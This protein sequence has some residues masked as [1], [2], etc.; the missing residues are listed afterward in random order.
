MNRAKVFAL[1]MLLA[2]AAI[3]VGG[4]VEA[5]MAG[6]NL[7]ERAT[8][9]I[10]ARQTPVPSLQNQ[11]ASEPS[12]CPAG[13]RALNMTNNCSE[14]IWFAENPS[15]APGG[16]PNCPDPTNKDNDNFGCPTGTTCNTGGVCVTSCTEP[17]MVNPPDC[18]PN[19]TCTDGGFKQMAS[20]S[21]TPTVTI[22]ECFANFYEPTPVST[23]TSASGSGWDLAPNG[24][25][26]Q[27]CVPEAAP[28]AGAAP[29]KSCTENS[30]CAS[31]ACESSGSKSPM[32]S[33][34]NFC[35]PSESGCKCGNTITWSGLFW[36]RT[37][38]TLSD[39][40]TRLSCQTGDCNG[41][42][43][44]LVGPPPP[45]TL[46]EMTLL[47][48]SDPGATDNYDISMV[49]G[50]NVGYSIQG[51]PGTYD[52]SAT[53][54]DPGVGCNFNINAN[55]PAELQLKNGNNVIGCY[56]PDKACDEASP[57]A[58]LNCGGNVPFKCGTAADCPFGHQL[59][60]KS[61][62]APQQTM[63][64]N[65]SGDCVCKKNSDCP[66][67]FS[68]TGGSCTAKS[69]TSATW[70][71]LYGC[72]NFY[73]LSPYN[74]NIY[75]SWLTGT[76]QETGITCGC[77]SWSAAG[78]CLA[79]NYN[80]ETAPIGGGNNNTV[81]DY[82]QVFH[83][84]CPTA[85]SYAYDDVAGTASC[86]PI[87]QATTGPS[88]NIEFCPAGSSATAT[89]TATA[90]P[91]ATAT[92]TVTATTTAT[93]TVTA[94]ATGT[95]TATPTATST[96]ATSTPTVTATATA[97]ATST[98]TPTATATTTGTATPTATATAT[99]TATPTVTP[100]ATITSTPTASST[101]TPTTTA[102]P[103]ATP[104][105]TPGC[106]P[107]FAYMSTNPD[108]TLAFGDVPPRG[109]VTMTLMVTNG[110]PSATLKLSEKI[111]TA[112]AKDF[113]V[114]GGTCTTTKKKLKAGDTC[115]YKIKLKGNRSD[116]GDAVNTNFVITG[117]YNPGVCPAGDVQTQTV[118]LAG[119]VDAIA[120]GNQPGNS[121]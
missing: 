50:F 83:N 6:S 49:S 106:T 43:D 87:A 93:P 4:G 38:C 99:S 32:N 107:D 95:A 24:G 48:P 39:D 40:G 3:L 77:P 64:C 10:L 45:A 116:Q 68:C 112:D 63:T 113:S 59:N 44:C 37:G 22:Y 121:Q 57:P 52:S 84:G 79:D 51:V 23:P 118:T 86:Q 103:T 100:T 11:P 97:T 81:E 28:T 120:A 12:A 29:G 15:S 67:G 17:G 54:S 20:P 117:M 26:A 74:E 92:P 111:Q 19:Q 21:A 2:A 16:T 78:D 31:Y 55:C 14:D 53:C 94:T 82:Y 70:T 36:G 30:D 72:G 7:S 8:L 105:G 60:S 47:V 80:W 73:N 18:G 108:G 101:A 27:I 75:P 61:K 25:E 13:Y 41:D 90:T 85:Y 104:T 98:A 119:F 35:L 109:S 46:A 115:N 62:D 58:T 102:T 56:T 71:D 114:V 89:P 1:L 96:S 65:S 110:E 69:G 76:A 9:S 5:Q 91:S 34:G 33:P 42:V 66:S 88:Y